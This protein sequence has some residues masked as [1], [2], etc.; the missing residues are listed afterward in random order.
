MEMIGWRALFGI[1]V[2]F[3]LF[4]SEPSDAQVRLSPL[5]ERFTQPV[6]LFHSGDGSG[7]L[8]I[9]EQAG[10]IRTW[11]AGEVSTFLDVRDRVISGGETGLLG[12]AF[13]PKFATN[14]RF[15]VNYTSKAGGLQTLIAEW[16]V[17]HASGAVD[18][19]SERILLTIPQPYANHN[20]GQIA[21]GLDGYLYIGMGDGGSANDPHGHGQN[22]ATLL[23]K[24]LRI[25]VDRRDARKPYG[26]P[27]DNP[28]VG[29]PKSAPEIWALGLRNPWRFSFD[30]ASGLLY[31]GDVGQSAREEIDVIRKGENY[32]WKVMEGTIC[33][34]SVGEK[35]DRQGLTPP[36]FDYPRSD[37][38][39][40][41]GGYVY[42]GKAIPMLFGYYIYGDFGNGKIWALQ[43]DGQQVRGWFH[44]LST[45][46]NISAFG[47]DETGELYVVDYNGTI[48]KMVGADRQ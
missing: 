38:T 43:Y 2:I 28:F 44:L 30:R 1:G 35:C 8:F 42:R 6:G 10:V 17:D 15:F 34:P 23:G 33:T 14:G 3:C 22:R 24:M 16:R 7:R 18:R 27:P 4:F 11:K 32:G 46:R 13:H 48:L 26:I 40:V 31:A 9:V 5:A 19:K 29:H 20:G 12:L 39:V 41:I 47:E 21:F 45:G 37:G 25:D 36:I